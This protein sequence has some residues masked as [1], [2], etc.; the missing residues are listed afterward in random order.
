MALVNL[1]IA[2]KILSSVV[3]KNEIIWTLIDK[4]FKTEPF[5]ENPLIDKFK[6]TINKSITL[7]VIIFLAFFSV[8]IGGVQGNLNWEIIL[9][10]FHQTASTV[11][12]PIF[13]KQLSFYFFSL[14]FY[15]FISS[16]IVVILIIS[17]ISLFIVYF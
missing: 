15:N 12:D 5:Y 2:R 6:N 11:T 16:L 4:F 3:N 8:L 1:L 7:V 17:I 14:P 13:N 9:K 10:F